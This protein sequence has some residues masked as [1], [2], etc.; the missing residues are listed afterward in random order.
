MTTDPRP[1]I[2]RFSGAATVFLVAICHQCGIVLPFDSDQRR[3]AW[4]VEHQNTGHRIEFA[5]DVRPDPTQGTD[6][7]VMSMKPES[8]KKL[9]ARDR[10]RARRQDRQWKDIE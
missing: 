4:A 8:P 7:Q 2:I 1:G 3:I 5:V 6:N 10:R 9:N